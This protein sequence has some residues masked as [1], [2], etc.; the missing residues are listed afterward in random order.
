MKKLTI[1]FVALVLAF[2]AVPAFAGTSMEAD[3]S[4]YGQARMWT[5]WESVDSNTPNI[6]TGTQVSPFRGAYA[7][8]GYANATRWQ[9]AGGEFHSDAGLAWELQSNSR[10][11][12]IVK[13]GSIGGQVELGLAGT[14]YLRLAYGTWN[15][16]SGTFLVG[17]DYTP[18][19]SP[20]TNMCGIG[21]GECNGI[22]FG[23]WYTG[24]QP[25]LKL[26]FGG[27]Q[28]ALV[29]PYTANM[30]WSLN[31]AATGP[32][33]LFVAPANLKDKDQFIPDLEAAYRFTA[34]P[35][36][37]SVGGWYGSARYTTSTLA[38]LESNTTIDAWGFNA[39][40]K[41]AFGP[42]YL[43]GAVI[44]ARN[45]NDY[46]QYTDLLPTFA[47]VDA[48]GDNK[49][50]ASYFA[51]QLVSGFK[52]TD[53]LAFEGGVFYQYGKV[54]G[55]ATTLDVKENVWVYYLQAS[56]SPAKNVFIVPEIGMIDYGKLK[57]TDSPDLD[58]G[59]IKWLGIK[60]QINF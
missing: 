50:N 47:L 11:G 13:W 57:V 60:W 15:F 42:F 25:Q 14:P 16:G 21:G 8:Q 6:L 55:P 46:Q 2:A 34:G 3:W 26:T 52:V 5:A 22:G 48:N 38:N 4:F 58:V 28:V 41:S 31:P 24:R 43:N 44:W 54:K 18:S 36:A 27:F 45:P 12:A 37:M 1:L 17:Q 7:Y 9:D 40:A 19:F 20:V 10:F 49:E 59:N 35:V 23:T 56:F 29:R 51:A 39:T 30:F 32:D 53:S 33:N